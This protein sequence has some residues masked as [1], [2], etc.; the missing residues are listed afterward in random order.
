M[1]RDAYDLRNGGRNVRSVRLVGV[2][3]LILGAMIA[4]PPPPAG[5]HPRGNFS[6][7]HQTRGE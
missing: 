1:A 3:A 5:A 2:T 4:G 6:I 7:N